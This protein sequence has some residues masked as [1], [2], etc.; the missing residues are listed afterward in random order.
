[1]SDCAM[2]GCAMFVNEHGRVQSVE[3]VR[4]AVEYPIPTSTMNT[5]QFNE[6]ST[7]G[8]PRLIDHLWMTQKVL[9]CA[10]N[11]TKD[12]TLHQCPFSIFDL[13][14]LFFTSTSFSNDITH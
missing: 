13:S 11:G 4:V 10:K 12:L 5:Y 9:G 2:S 1:M 3:G 7:Y 6:H 14:S 8:C